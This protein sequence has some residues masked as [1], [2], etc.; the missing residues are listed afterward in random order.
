MASEQTA[1]PISAPGTFTA[2]RYCTYDVPFWARPNSRDGRWHRVGDLPTQYWSLTPDAAWA[3]LIRAEA[4]ASEE[5]LDQVRMPLWVCTVPATLVID[6]RDP[7]AHERYELTLEQLVAD[8]R[9]ACQ[10]AAPAIRTRARGV[11]APSAA[12]DGH[13]NLTLFGARR[14]IGW[15]SHPALA[16]TVPATLAA[17][18]R[19]PRGLLQRV[20]RPAALP[21][22]APLF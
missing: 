15:L 18:G 16:S 7:A 6:L 2:F 4:L 19:P 14:P 5:E 20:R 8:D 1:L 3:E 10:A 9:K 13:P 12:L 11:I 21:S 17:I 22:Q